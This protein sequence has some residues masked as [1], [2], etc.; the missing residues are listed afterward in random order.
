MGLVASEEFRQKCADNKKGFV[1][2]EEHRRKISQSK[3][4]FSPMLGKRLTQD[5]KDKIRESNK[6]L[7]RAEETKQKMRNKFNYNARRHIFSVKCIE[8]NEVFA[9]YSAAAIKFGVSVTTISNAVK[10]NKVISR[11]YHFEKVD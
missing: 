4:G 10:N 3:R 7:R 6:G 2:T 11:K 5:H 8:T 9:S 1:F